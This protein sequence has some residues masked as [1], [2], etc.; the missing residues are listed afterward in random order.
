MVSWFAISAPKDH[1]WTTN[2]VFLELHFPAE[3]VWPVD[4][5]IDG[6]ETTMNL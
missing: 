1:P 2:P 6:N 3:I 5:G 4:S